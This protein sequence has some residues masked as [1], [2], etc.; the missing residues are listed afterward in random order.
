VVIV[1]S[2]PKLR[3]VSGGQV[4]SVSRFLLTKKYVKNICILSPFTTSQGRQVYINYYI[5]VKHT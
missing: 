5:S 1:G 3:L 4:R 2:G